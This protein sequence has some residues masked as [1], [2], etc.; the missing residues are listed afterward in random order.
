MAPS[1]DPDAH[2]R[3]SLRLRDYDYDQL[4]AYFVTICTR[5]RVPLFGDVV[6]GEIQLS[7]YGQIV[8]EE[9]AYTELIRARVILD[10]YVIMPNHVHDV[11]V[12]ADV[13]HATEGVWPYAPTDHPR[14]HPLRSPSLTIGA[15]VRGFKG[16]AT[17]R[18]NTA[19]G[20]PRTPVW[21][22]NYYEHVIRDDANLERIRS[23]ITANPGR[24]AEDEENP[25]RIVRQRR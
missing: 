16:A 1:R 14:G 19:R 23:Y 24:W 5:E 2:H 13:P 3:R 12:I 7:A 20:T 15:I 21:Q 17:T 22:R 10:A 11:V 6:D 25:A 8:N 9:W 4:G 18:I